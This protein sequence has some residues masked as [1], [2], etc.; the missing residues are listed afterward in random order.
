MNHVKGFKAKSK[1][2]KGPVVVQPEKPAGMPV[3][4]KNGLTLFIE[5]TRKSGGPADLRAINQLWVQKGAEG[6]KEFTERAEELK[7]KYES[8]M[9][10]FQRTA[11]G[12]RY[13]RLKAAADRKLRLINAKKRF[14][15][16]ANAPKEPKR[17][18]S[19]Y[20]LFL[21]EKSSSI[22]AANRGDKAKEL[23]AVWSSMSPE[24]KKV[25]EDKAKELKDKYD[26]EMK[27]YKSNPN[28]KK[29]EKTIDVVTG[30]RAREIARA[31]AKR[32][33]MEKARARVKAARPTPGASASG[34]A[35][36]APAAK[37]GSDSDEMG[38]DSSSSSKSS[39]SSSSSDSD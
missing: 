13:I 24:E 28:Y 19:A 26:E 39:K 23:T 16:D 12:K 21:S 27:A 30:K 25:F 33:A 7:K 38:S 20:F 34:A 22:S 17:P 14:L 1:A 18:A 31:K 6:Q 35:A 5:E 37:G 10:Q 4:P 36:S 8:D 2:K 9:I 3:L 11:E 32:A 15:G 29:Y